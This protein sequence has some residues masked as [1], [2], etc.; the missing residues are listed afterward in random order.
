MSRN[1]HRGRGQN[2]RYYFRHDRGGRDHY[3][4]GKYFHNYDYSS[5]YGDSWHGN[6]KPRQDRQRKPNDTTHSDRGYV[7]MQDRETGRDR[8]TRSRGEGYRRKEHERDGNWK[9]GEKTR[10]QTT[11]KE[12]SDVTDQL[13]HQIKTEMKK[14]S[15]KESNK[16]FGSEVHEYGNASQNV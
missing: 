4:H 11:K 16:K 5:H 2:E 12:E 1:S 8:G 6:G 14:D 9:R 10:S 3:G 15:Q 7:Y 13:K